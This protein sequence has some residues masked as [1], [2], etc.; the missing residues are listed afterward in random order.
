MTAFKNQ[1]VDTLEALKQIQD[2]LMADNLPADDKE[3]TDI[4]NRM[5]KTIQMI[6]ITDKITQ[7]NLDVL[8]VDNYH[9]IR[10][11]TEK[12]MQIF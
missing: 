9:T 6:G 3:I 11:A 2:S 7:S 1:S 4:E 8:T 10:R 12:A 5:I